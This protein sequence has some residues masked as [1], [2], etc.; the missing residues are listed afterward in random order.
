MVIF[1]LV[2][3]V[4]IVMLSYCGKRN[5]TGM[6]SV[7]PEKQIHTY[8]SD[9]NVND[10]GYQQLVKKAK[11][12]AISEAE[13]HDQSYVDG[14]FAGSSQSKSNNP[15]TSDDNKRTQAKLKSLDPVSFYDRMHEQNSDNQNLNTSVDQNAVGSTKPFSAPPAVKANFEALLKAWNQAPAMQQQTGIMETG[16]GGTSNATSGSEDIMFK[17]GDVLFAVIDTA[18]NSDQPNTPVLARIVTGPYRNAK[19]L[20]TFTREEDKLV[21]KFNTLALKNRPSS[22]PINAY[23]IDQRTAQTAMA[24][25]VDHHYLM[26]YGSLFAASFLQGFGT[27]FS[28]YQAY[29]CP[30]NSICINTDTNHLNPVSE[31]MYSGLGQIG[32]SLSD[33]VIKNFNKPPTVTLD[34]GSPIGVLIM[35]DVNRNGVQVKQLGTD[36]K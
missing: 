33:S 30:S 26:R 24:T 27:Y 13:A 35:S 3:I 9:H 19:L 29:Q 21:I 32:T 15:A 18:I 23:A 11:G 20:G 34:Q 28:N 8:P 2:I 7:G 6:K 10:Q 17:A 5:G 14:L 16:T 1:L 31:A 36:K 4:S 25:N 12:R 22:I